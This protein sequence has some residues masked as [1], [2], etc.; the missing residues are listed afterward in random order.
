MIATS[1]GHSCFLGERNIVDLE[2]HA[3]HLLSISM[4]SLTQFHSH[5]IT[6]SVTSYQ[7]RSVKPLDRC[8]VGGQLLSIER[9]HSR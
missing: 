8:I 2:S 4:S 3:M 6:E 5:S 9:M 1:D 7:T